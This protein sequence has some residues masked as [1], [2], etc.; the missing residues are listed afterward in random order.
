MLLCSCRLS[1]GKRAAVPQ[2]LTR[3]AAR[4]TTTTAPRLPSY[5]SAPRRTSGGRDMMRLVKAMS[6]PSRSSE[7][8]EYSSPSSLM[9]PSVGSVT[10]SILRRTLHHVSPS[11]K[12][13]DKAG[14]WKL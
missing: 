5:P 4:T 12:S 7:A 10:G 14:K 8:E 3:G 9:L 11:K 13:S 2:I 6:P 1:A